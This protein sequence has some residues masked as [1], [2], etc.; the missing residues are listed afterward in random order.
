MRLHLVYARLK[1]SGKAI[2][3]SNTKRQ[4]IVAECKSKSSEGQEE[5]RAVRLSC[6]WGD[7]KD[8]YH[9]AKVAKGC[10]TSVI[11]HSS[12]SPLTTRPHPRPRPHP[13]SPPSIVKP[14]DASS[15]FLHERS[16]IFQT[17]VHPSA[18]SLWPSLFSLT[19]SLT[20]ERWHRTGNSSSCSFCLCRARDRRQRR[21]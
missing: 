21:P 19:C 12:S 1:R 14:L 4:Y 16:Q 17:H 11:A 2:L 6:V 3:L 9:A 10:C 5:T 8:V 7:G 18:D 13:T 20:D 15:T